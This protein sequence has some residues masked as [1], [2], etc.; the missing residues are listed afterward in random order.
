MRNTITKK[1]RGL[2]RS[3]ACYLPFQD[4]SFDVVYSSR[5]V[6]NVLTE[7]MQQGGSKRDFFGSLSLTATV[8]LMENFEEPMG[9]NES[10]QRGLPVW[11][12]DC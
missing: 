2:C 10:R 5:C 8:V 9:P 6:I 12:S 11:T 7:E 1:A 3:D 4:G